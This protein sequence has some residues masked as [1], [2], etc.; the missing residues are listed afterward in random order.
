[1]IGE[2]DKNFINDRFSRKI[3]FLKY[4]Q[5]HW[6]S[7]ADKVYEIVKVINDIKK[8]DTFVYAPVEDG[9]FESN[10]YYPVALYSE[11]L[12]DTS[13]DIKT[14]QSMVALRD[15]IKFV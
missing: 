1:M 2:S 7:N 10:V 6:L 13:S 9:V 3:P 15:Y 4:I 5:A 8:G 12:W 11:M 14:L